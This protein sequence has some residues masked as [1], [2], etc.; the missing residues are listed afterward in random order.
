VT[1]LAALYPPEA[2]DLRVVPSMASP[3]KPDT[4]VGIRNHGTARD[5]Y[6]PAMLEEVD[7]GPGGR[8]AFIDKA[9]PHSRFDT[10][11]LASNDEVCTAVTDL[12]E[13]ESEF[14]FRAV[15]AFVGFVSDPEVVAQFG[16]DGGH[17]HVSYN[18]DLHTTDRE[19]SMFY[20]K[21]FHL[22]LNYFP[23]RDL[24]LEPATTWAKLE[25]RALA[26]RLLDPVAYLAEPVV[27]DVNSYL[28]GKVPLLPVD[29]RR[30]LELGLTAGPKLAVA[31]WGAVETRETVGHLR[32]LHE[33]AERAYLDLHEA[34]T[35][36]PF[37]PREW[38]RPPLLD[39]EETITRVAA[40]PWVSEE[41]LEGL[42][43]LARALRP[44]DEAG[45]AAMRRDPG[46]LTQQLSLG[47]LDY[48]VS[49]T[50]PQPNTR[51][52]PAS[53]AP[54]VYF[55]QQIKLF[56]DIGGAG[57][58]SMGEVNIVRLDRA[59]GQVLRPEEVDER[60]AFGNRFREHYLDRTTKG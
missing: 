15:P 34:F 52:S 57:M 44:V 23:P 53:S 39:L 28:G 56:A 4:P 10:M 54:V 8:I 48:A 17:L 12:S 55:T 3:R 1:R 37:I 21:R 29:R 26:Q 16:L 40:L 41:S 14:V 47:G 9:F 35:G 43:A 22:H 30:D 20:D 13:P 42:T 33:A 31:G 11:L 58:P 36:E 7:V 45:I 2:A 6:G 19:N 60:S 51:S 32:H 18:Y 38:T 49:M 59:S 5:F 25:D 50:T 27:R 46:L 24:D